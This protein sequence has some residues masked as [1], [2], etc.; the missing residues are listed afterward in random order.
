MAYLR[1]LQQQSN[2]N[3]CTRFQPLHGDYLYIRLFGLYHDTGTD[4]DM[5]CQR[6]VKRGFN[7]QRAGVELSGK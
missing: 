5:L 4:G 1:K 6:N 3:G 2:R 7:L